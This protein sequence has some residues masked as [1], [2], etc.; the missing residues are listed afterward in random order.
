MKRTFDAPVHHELMVMRWAL[1]KN[2]CEILNQVSFSHLQMARV[3]KKTTESTRRHAFSS[4]KERVDSIKIEPSRK[5]NIRAHD[6]VETSHFLVTLEHWKEVNLS[7]NFSEFVHEVEPWCQ[8]LP[9]ILHH[10][11]NIYEALHQH[12]EKNDIHSMQPLLELMSQF[13]HDLGPDFMPFYIRYL[14]L[15]VKL[16]QETNPND[17]QNMKNTSNVL[18]WCFNSL[19]FA[20][21]YLSR[22]LVKDL[23]PTLTELI[24]VLLM[25][26]KTYVSR[27]CGE[28]LSF[29]V[30]KQKVED[31]KM[32]VQFA[33]TSQAHLLEENSF[34]RSSL[35]VLFSESMKNTK[36]TFHSKA[37]LILSVLVENA[38]EFSQ[39][40]EAFVSII[41]DILLE[42]LHHGNESEC[43]R[44][45]LNIIDYLAKIVQ[46]SE[47]GKILVFAPQIL[48]ALCFADSGRKVSSWPDVF[49]LVKIFIQEVE[50]KLLDDEI[51]HLSVITALIHLFAII[52]RNCDLQELTK[53]FETLKN[54]LL[55]IDGGKYFL[56]FIESSMIMAPEKMSAFNVNKLVQS[57]ANK[58]TSEDD[59]MRLSLAQMKLTKEHSEMKQNLS[60][61]SSIKQSVIKLFKNDLKHLEDETLLNLYWKCQIMQYMCDFKEVD[62]EVFLKALLAITS[63]KLGNSK[64]LHDIIG[65]LLRAI[66]QATNGDSAL[67]NDTLEFAIENLSDLKESQVFVDAL[68]DFLKAFGAKVQSKLES[69]SASFCASIS[70]NFI[71]PERNIR[72]ASAELLF[73]FYSVIGSPAPSVLSEMRI[74]DQIP[75]AV[76]N[77]NDVKMRIRNMYTTFGA[78]NHFEELELSLII[79]FSMG[80]LSNHFQPCWLAVYE[81]LPKIANSS[82]SSK[83]SK[84]LLR[85]LEFD[86]QD[87]S[88]LYSP[89]EPQQLGHEESSIAKSQPSDERFSTSFVKVLETVFLSSAD[90]LA[91]LFDYSKINRELHL[92][93]PLLRARVIKAL[94]SVPS[95]AESL[96]SKLIDISVSLM[97]DDNEADE[98]EELKG[99][100]MKDKLELIAV[101]TKFRSL[102]KVEG[103]A[104]LHALMLHCLTSRQS[105]VQKQALDVIFAFNKPSV[106]KYKDNL[107]NLLDDKLFRDELQSLTASGSDSKIEQEDTNDVIPIVLRILY[108]RAKGASSGS[109]KSSRKFAIATVLPNL[110][111]SYIKQFLD[112]VSERI[113]HSKFFD[114]E[115]VPIVSKQDLKNMVGYLNMLSDVYNA[116]GLK[117]GEVLRSTI[118]PLIYCLVVAQNFID[119]EHEDEILNKIA[120][121]IRQL[122]F[123]CLNTLFKILIGTHSWSQEAPVLYNLVVRPR[124]EHFANENA[125]QPSSLMQIMLGWIESTNL[126]PF[127]YFED[128]APVKAIMSLLS[129]PHTKDTVI[130]AIL[131]FCMAALM[132]KDVEGD[133]YFKVLALIVDGLLRVLPQILEKSL[134]RDINTKAST[135]L[136]LAIEGDFINDNDTKSRLITASTL[137]LNK[138]PFQISN[139]DKVSILLSLASL[140]DGFDCSFADIEPLYEVC[141]KAFRSYKDRNV[142]E[143]LVK[144]FKAM[145]RT[146]VELEQTAYLLEELNSY[147]PRRMAEPDFDRRISAFKII[148]GDLSQKMTRLQWLPI[149]YSSLFFINDTEEISLR[150]NG[151]YVL[152]R[153]VDAMA[154][155]PSLSDAEELIGVFQSVVMPYIRL[156]LRKE[157][158]NVKEEYVGVLAHIVRNSDYVPL[159]AKMKVLLSDEDDERDFFKGITH[160]QIGA[161]QRS[162][163]LLIELRN[164]IGA[165]CLYHYILPITETYIVCKDERYRNILD[166]T[167]E[168]WS[169]LVRCLNWNDFKQLFKKHL[170]AVTKSEPQYLR[171]NVNILVRISQALLSS[172]LNAKNNETTDVMEDWPEQSKI[173]SFVTKDSLPAIM[174]ILKVRDDETVVA[175]TPLVEVAVDLLLCAS[176]EITEVELPGTLTSTCQVL[177]SRTQ[178]LRDA[179]RKTLSRVAKTLG[180]RYFRFIV[181]ELKSA[182]S[183]GAQIHVLSYTLHS[184][185]VAV[186]DSYESGD[187]D[188]SCQMIVAIIMEDTFGA[189]GQEKDAE[190]YVSK[191]REVKSKK[192]YDSAEILSSNITLPN[193][194]LIVE[195][196]KLLLSV[197]L[198]TKTLRKLDEL[199]RRYALGLNHNVQSSTREMLLLCYELHKQSEEPP[200]ARKEVAQPTEAEDHF[201]VKLDAKPQRISRDNSQL[202][203]TL[204]RM[205]FELLRTALGRH[206]D[207]L[208]VANVDGFIPLMEKSIA[209]ESETVL[210]PLYRVLDLIIKLPFAET[211]DAF[212]ER[213]A[214]EAF[215]I[216]QNSPTTTTDLCQICL[217]YLA[218]VVRHKQSVRLNNSAFS[219]L[220][221]RILPDLEEPDKQGLAFN[222]LKAV[223]SQHV[224]LPEVYDV[225]DKVSSIMVV[226]HAKEIRDM[227]RSIYFLFLME[228]EQG[229][230]KLDKAFKFLVTNLSYPT[231]EGRQSV[232]EL[233]HSLTLRSS[234]TLF[235][236]L[237]SSFFVG[238]ANVIVSDDSPK[239]REMAT[240][241]VKQIFVKLGSDKCHDLEKFCDSWITQ[242]V[243]VLLQRCGLLVYKIYLTV[244][245]YGQNPDLDLHA[246]N[247]IS[248]IINKSKSTSNDD[249]IEWE[250]VYSS[251]NV[252]SS[253]CSTLKEN[254]FGA[255]FEDIWKDVLD[256]LLYPHTWVRLI[257]AK[258][259][260]LL[261]NHLD[262]VKFDI[263]DYEIQ[264]IAYRTLRQFGAPVVSEALGTQIVKNL[265]QIIKK[266]E[267]EE[268]PFYY[269]EDDAEEVED[270]DFEADGEIGAKISGS[271]KFN[272]ATDFVVYRVCSIMRQDTKNH[273][274]ATKICS[275]QLAAMICQIV[276][277]ERLT[278]ISKQ[279]LLGLYHLIDPLVDYDYPEEVVAAA[280]ECL[281]ILEDRLGVTKYTETFSAVKRII[282]ERREKRRS[283]RAQLTFSAPDIAARRKMRKHE[284]FREKRKHEKDENGFY[285]PKRKRTLR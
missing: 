186:I 98:L 28:A 136:L 256:T 241:L 61:P 170:T 169:Y 264:T 281:K 88:G 74:I 17:S 160:I 38:L 205:S 172:S 46:S 5:L 222:F 57:Y 199:L 56:S 189:A 254:V 68:N 219:Y 145:S 97:G 190:D 273:N 167:H 151:A 62:G 112:I 79:N 153:F 237:A 282:D 278:E 192:S 221:T 225:M 37:T 6:Y 142:R 208:N 271:N 91:A 13:I 248:A 11:S 249:D 31:L 224:M 146:F 33:F 217:R 64:F 27:F 104:K 18:E 177:R 150:S 52:I 147:S 101:F 212:F 85:F 185:L 39:Q 244:F 163:K 253:V 26:K 126:V 236:Q 214:M 165:D 191:M 143:S 53:Y 229:T 263:S 119:G 50:T 215:T 109:N 72:L 16:A 184:L 255:S 274:E 162:L 107:K 152:K 2:A 113:D 283:K 81:G 176:T 76:A 232:M 259:V 250:D 240:A 187:L 108:G 9:Q 233:M 276:N 132:K 141:S 231:Q 168:A 54:A 158:D 193:F 30:K 86:Y 206:S 129:N 41:C 12:I 93:K 66:I 3:Q 111:D 159:F 265:I 257:S 135:I 114:N 197:N 20:F 144:V 15:I 179:V 246:L 267:A 43:A 77:S 40:S 118:P 148:N 51:L 29:L 69:C 137:A 19:A 128:F 156:G 75:L 116:L 195:P 198:P 138:S 279:I 272:K 44:F 84:L 10:Q 123:K 157:D 284:R 275:I 155:K 22:T 251:L 209:S 117:Y 180:A 210:L 223:V 139:N 100:S 121:N 131:D 48:I 285:K 211:R 258:L 65:M 242:E 260:G 268:T 82:S 239:C 188:E 106:N 90:V 218:S 32:T 70:E 238:L 207:L 89:Y 178:H 171:D 277:D 203:F 226:N 60:M 175:R 124:L 230:K 110:P 45:Y 154:S 247:A 36:E 269:K 55:D 103:Q 196:I 87:Q 25:T 280:K 130:T 245:G 201:L 23:I 133:E 71:L 105:N 59:L 204:Q 235:S 194:R 173:D 125:Q 99:W 200:R 95:V 80:L 34:Y 21:K 73:T 202:L 182:L 67:V 181:K 234:E 252:F 261:L 120:R 149:L 262:S 243:N 83:I 216:I 270:D 102:R 140:L 7:G 134:D 96:A 164:E 266:W 183:R 58:I 174:K 49:G 1:K 63:A 213:T 122:G 227:S 166:D 92:Y 24:P 127:L 14:N 228:Y 161:R 47:N 4:F 42:V 220:L 94:Q 35:V 78:S 8:T 115:E